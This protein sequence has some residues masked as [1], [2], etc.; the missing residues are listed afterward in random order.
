VSIVTSAHQIWQILLVTYKGKNKVKESKI[1]ILVF[2]FELFKMKENES[3][4]KMTTI[5]DITN[6]LVAIGKEYTQVEKVRNVLR[7]LTFNWEKKTTAVE[8]ANN[9]STLT[10]ENIIGNLMAYEV[11]IEDKNKDEQQHPKKKVLT[12]HAS[13][14]MKD[15][16]NEKGSMNLDLESC[17]GIISPSYFELGFGTQPSLLYS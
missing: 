2:M 11:Q 13:S 17:E 3:I 7:A 15:S 12:F 9:L 5:S 8:E 6:S 4:A 16:D 10:L 14:D 1:S